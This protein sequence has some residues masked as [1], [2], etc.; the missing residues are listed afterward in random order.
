MQ[1]LFWSLVLVTTL[2]VGCKAASAPTVGADPS[3]SESANLDPEAPGGG[4]RLATAPVEPDPMTFGWKAGDRVVVTH[5]HRVDEETVEVRYTLTVTEEPQSFVLTRVAAEV[6]SA[7][8]VDPSTA[9]GERKLAA[10]EARGASQLRMRVGKDGRWLGLD[11][12]AGPRTEPSSASLVSTQN[13]WHL[14]VAHWIGLPDQRG[15]VF[16]VTVPTSVGPKTFD[17]PYTIEVNNRDD[18]PGAHIRMVYELAGPDVSAAMSQA[19]WPTTSARLTNPADLEWA[20]RAASETAYERTVVVDVY[21]D[22]ATLRPDR[23]SMK[24]VTVVEV[25]ELSRSERRESDVWTFVWR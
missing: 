21:T 5:T 13:F 18:G 14:W 22:P 17:T 6:L 20:K 1:P 23:V 2:S 25:G 15:G 24:S 9:N 8:G 16:Q 3:R 11:T 7:P 10:L 12:D 4:P 19:A